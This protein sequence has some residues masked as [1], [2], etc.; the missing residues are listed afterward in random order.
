VAALGYAYLIGIVLGLLAAV[1]LAIW[2][3]FASGTLNWLLLKVIWIPLVLVGLVLRSMWISIP[4]PDGKEVQREQA[5]EL[6][7]L[8]GE[9]RT[10][11]EGPAVHHVLLSDEFNAGIVQVP[12]FGMFG[13]TVNYL[14]LGLPLMKAIGPNEF[15][16]VIAHEFGHLSGKHGKFSGWV[17]HLRQSW[18]QVLTNVQQDRH[19]ASFLFDWFINWYAPYFDAYSVPK[20][21]LLDLDA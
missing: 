5:P 13:W 9:V 2:A 1:G 11:V 14:V 21:G 20:L 18:V 10:A 19:Y 3:M 4:P 6:F 8:I 16:A 15:R 7:G 12:K 17:Y